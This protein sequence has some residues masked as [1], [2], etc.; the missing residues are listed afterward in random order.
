M[1][2]YTT[3]L[4]IKRLFI[5]ASMSIFILASADALSYGSGGYTA[6][7]SNAAEPDQAVYFIEPKNNATVDQEFTIKMGIRGMAIKPAGDMTP[8]TGH[9]H[10]LV[11]ESPVRKNEV[12]PSSPTHL[13]FGKGQTK[14]T[15]TLPPGKHT[16]TLQFAD[17]AHRSYGFAMRQSITVHVK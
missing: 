4:S 5:Y 2:S 12:I 17:G 15:L 11:D 13:H 16:L 8:N 3:R 6:N 1:S 10:L 9:H 14:T 7:P